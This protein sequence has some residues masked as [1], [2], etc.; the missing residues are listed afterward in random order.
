MVN[1]ITKYLSFKKL[2]SQDYAF[3]TLQVMTTW[4]L[5]LGMKVNITVIA[6]PQINST[7]S[8]S[9]I[10]KETVFKEHP[11]LMWRKK[12]QNTKSFVI[13]HSEAPVFRAQLIYHIQTLNRSKM[14]I[15]HGQFTLQFRFDRIKSGLQS[16]HLVLRTAMQRTLRERLGV[17]FVDMHQFNYALNKALLLPKVGSFKI[18]LYLY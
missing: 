1:S 14:D 4:N 15:H 5:V 13:I 7:N 8:R 10:F 3:C 11:W 6:T 18:S 2:Y 17:R 9:T 12:I 16:Y